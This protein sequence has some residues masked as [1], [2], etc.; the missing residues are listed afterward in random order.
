[1]NTV[2]VYGDCHWWSAERNPLYQV[3]CVRASWNAKKQSVEKNLADKFQLRARFSRRRRLHLSSRKF[4]G[5]S[6]LSRLL[7]AGL[8]TLYT[9]SGFAGSK[10]LLFS[11]FSF[12]APALDELGSR[13][14]HRF[15]LRGLSL[16]QADGI[17]LVSHAG[18]GSPNGQ[19]L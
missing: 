15:V 14:L 10:F 2:P 16:G 17:S 18:V 7:T 5:G 13:L 4:I 1:M 6:L 12:P 8:H 19:G 11:E 3:W 9:L